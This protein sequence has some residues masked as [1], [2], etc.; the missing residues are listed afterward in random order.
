MV[1]DLFY[2]RRTDEKVQA[3][4]EGEAFFDDDFINES[5]IWR[6]ALSVEIPITVPGGK[7][8]EAKFFA[9]RRML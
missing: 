7:S 6:R 1:W 8:M 5:G 9:R 2:G 3:I 4:R